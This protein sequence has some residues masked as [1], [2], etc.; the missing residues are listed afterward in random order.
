MGTRTSSGSKNSERVARRRC[1]C[2]APRLAQSPGTS[3]GHQHSATYSWTAA[4][5]GGWGRRRC[6]GCAGW[7]PQTAGRRWGD[8]CACT[9][10]EPGPGVVPS[11]GQAHRFPGQHY[12]RQTQLPFPLPPSFPPSSSRH[13]TILFALL[14]QQ[15]RESR[16]GAVVHGGL[17]ADVRHARSLPPLT[18]LVLGCSRGG[19]RHGPEPRRRRRSG[20]GQGQHRLELGSDPGTLPGGK[21]VAQDAGDHARRLV[22]VQRG[23]AG[24]RL[25]LLDL[26]DQLATGE[27]WL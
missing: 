5:A 3:S 19:R 11:E 7:I 26:R 20:Q 1:P 15:R 24:Q 8:L 12:A 9:E 13:L 21:G 10:L 2:R 25:D 6:A 4:C 27:R 17:A 16:D 14:E 22:R 23:P 18:G